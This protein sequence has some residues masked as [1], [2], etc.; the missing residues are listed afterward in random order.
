MLLGSPRVARELQS[1]L[2][3]L[4]SVETGEGARQGAASQLMDP[5]TKGSPGSFLTCCHH[6]MLLLGGGDTNLED[7]QTEWVGKESVRRG[8]RL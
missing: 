4:L 6:K 1:W 8:R 3:F 7:E 2:L 5:Q